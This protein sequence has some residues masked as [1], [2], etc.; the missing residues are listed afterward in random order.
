MASELIQV[1][2][3]SMITRRQNPYLLTVECGQRHHGVLV[4]VVDRAGLPVPCVVPGH[5]TSGAQ[6]R[7]AL[8]AADGASA[9]H[10][11]RGHV[12]QLR[13]LGHHRVTHHHRVA[14]ARHPE[15]GDTGSILKTN[16]GQMCHGGYD[17]SISS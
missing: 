16:E 10:Q 6:H 7:H 3:S 1:I 2:Q 11:E 13:H 8:D 9:G 12:G 5:V 15:T 14:G 4:V 17:L